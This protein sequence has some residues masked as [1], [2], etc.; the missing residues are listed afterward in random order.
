MYMDVC[1]NSGVRGNP[2]IYVD[3][4]VRPHTLVRISAYI[5]VHYNFLVQ[6]GRGSEARLWNMDASVV[7]P[8]FEPKPQESPIAGGI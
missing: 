8:G 7:Q 5:H 6:H 3:F 1:G 2:W 4:H